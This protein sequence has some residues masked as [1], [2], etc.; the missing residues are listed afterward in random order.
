VFVCVN[1]RDDRWRR[2]VSISQQDTMVDERK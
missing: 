1:V 2:R